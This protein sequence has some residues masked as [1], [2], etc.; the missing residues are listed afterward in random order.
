MTYQ[1]L[2][3]LQSSIHV[4]VELVRVCHLCIKTIIIIIIIKKRTF[5]YKISQS[6][7]D[8]HPCHTSS[9]NT[10]VLSVLLYINNALN[11]FVLMATT[12]SEIFLRG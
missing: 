4:S 6:N 3:R 1:S 8:I 11:T 5:R 2:A 10:N 12:T 7:V 9:I